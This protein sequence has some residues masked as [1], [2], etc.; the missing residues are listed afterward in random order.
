MTSHAQIKPEIG[1][2]GTV[3]IGSDDYP[4]TVIWVNASGTRCIVQD[5]KAE[6]APGHDYYQN[7]KYTFTRDPEGRKREFSLRKGGAWRLKGESAASGGY[8][9]TIG[10]RTKYC[11]PHF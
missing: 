10:E 7:Q 2:G 3:G 1:M 4:V 5:D 6:T 11:D 8:Y 9:L